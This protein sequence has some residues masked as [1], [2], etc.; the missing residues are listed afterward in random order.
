M[1]SVSTDF[2]KHSHG[3]QAVAKRRLIFK[4]LRRLFKPPFREPA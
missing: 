3:F 2:K 4:I 1:E